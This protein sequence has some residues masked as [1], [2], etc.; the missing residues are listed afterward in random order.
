MRSMYQKRKCGLRH[1]CQKVMPQETLTTT[2]K[3]RFLD[4]AKSS[5][6]YIGHSH[7]AGNSPVT[8]ELG[9]SAKYLMSLEPE[10]TKRKLQ[11]N[12]QSLVRS[13]L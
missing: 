9:L 5:A 10:V 11:I 13:V 6:L 1:F 4:S 3:Q 2:E 7:S 8:L 12:I